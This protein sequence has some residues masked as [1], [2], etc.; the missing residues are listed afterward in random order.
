MKNILLFTVILALAFMGYACDSSS[1]DP[2]SVEIEISVSS[3]DFQDV[4]FGEDAS[5]TITVTNAGDVI[6][7]D[8]EV[9]ISGEAYFANP[10]SLSLNP[11]NSQDVVVTFEPE[12]EGDFSGTLTV[13]SA[14]EGLSRSVNLSGFAVDPITGEWRSEGEGNVALG[15]AILAQTARI[16]AEFLSNNT[17]NVVSIDSS[18][19]EVQFSGTY[20]TGPLTDSG[21]RTIR[22]EQSVPAAVVSEGIF[23]IEGE[24]MT[25]EVIQTE[26]NIGAEAPTVEG[27]FG[28]TL[29]GGDPTG[30]L[31]IQQFARIEAE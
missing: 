10:N 2:D 31:W 29:V 30:I 4:R 8:L 1:S 28:S 21:I 14:S 19:T 5:E 6:L 3:L 12:T 25:Y 17:Y 26:P 13:A 24:N 18:G 11:G 16:D 15:L 20:T 7:D 9:T 27:G 22:L 23:R